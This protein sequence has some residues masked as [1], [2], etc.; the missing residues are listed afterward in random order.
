MLLGKPVVATH[1]SGNLT[2]MNAETAALVSYRLIPAIDP[3]GTYALA[4]GYWAEPDIA[5]AAGRLRALASDAA[6]RQALGEA[7]RAHARESLGAGPLLAA[8]AANGVT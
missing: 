2:F 5:D 4:G 8:L 7:G 3:R 1:W 6:A